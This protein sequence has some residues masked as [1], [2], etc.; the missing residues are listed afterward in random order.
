MTILFQGKFCIHSKLSIKSHSHI[1][2]KYTK[3]IIL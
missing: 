3:L 1:P 2:T